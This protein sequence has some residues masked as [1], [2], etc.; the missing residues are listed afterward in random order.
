MKEESKKKVL[1]REQIRTRQFFLYISPWLIGF[2]VFSLAPM[3]LSLVLSFTWGSKITTWTSKPLVFS[4]RNYIYIFTEDQVF[5]RSV[6]NT[7]AYAMIR[8]VGGILAATLLALLY[9]NDLFGKRLYRT[10]AYATSVI[11]VSAATIIW[12]TLFM[13]DNSLIQ[14]LL[15]SVGINGVDLFTKN[16][17][18]FTV[19]GLDIFVA[20]GST[21]IVVLAALQNVPMD[22]EEAAIIDGAGRIRRFWHITI[23][24]IS[25]GLMFISVTGFIGALQTYA[26]V[27]LL[28]GG[29]PEYSTITMTMSVIQRYNATNGSLCLGY[30]CAQA[31]I[32]FF[33]IMAFSLIYIKMIN[34]KVYYGDE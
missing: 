23:P 2:V 25:S 5:L 9:N 13:G 18:L 32:I 29:G 21:M 4:F 7:F 19:V 31:W 33:I 17:A 28:T 20:A 11:P 30:A 34:K 6:L 26:Q 3:I 27:K 24:M 16:N 1:T 12:S 14:R 15:V 8:V 10:M 22:L